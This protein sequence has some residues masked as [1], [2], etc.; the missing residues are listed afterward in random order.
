MCG[1][2]IL[3]YLSE[4]TRGV[5]SIIHISSCLTSNWES[6]Q[7]SMWKRQNRVSGFSVNRLRSYQCIYYRKQEA[8]SPWVLDEANQGAE[9]ENI[10]ICRSIEKKTD[11]KLH[12][13]PLCC[14]W[15]RAVRILPGL[16]AS[17][18]W[19]M[20]IWRINQQ[21]SGVPLASAWWVLP[22]Q[23]GKALTKISAT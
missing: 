23:N 17:E 3:K 1:G 22:N 10:T 21:S 2:I 16:W 8:A 18:T 6:G 9:K 15:L 4:N 19:R 13:W 12:A 14:P 11:Q 5:T 7:K 20:E